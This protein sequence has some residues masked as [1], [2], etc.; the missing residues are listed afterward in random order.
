MIRLVNILF[1]MIVRV[2]ARRAPV[3]VAVRAGQG[4]L[5][6][7]HSFSR[8]MFEIPVYRPLPTRWPER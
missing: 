3:G 4:R 8:L 1:W 5:V 7:L 2:L 6:D